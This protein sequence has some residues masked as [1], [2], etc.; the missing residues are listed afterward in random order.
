MLFHL[1]I[2]LLTYV[3]II[4]LSLLSSLLFALIYITETEVKTKTF[5]LK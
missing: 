1:F 2:D 4:T 5:E 3:L